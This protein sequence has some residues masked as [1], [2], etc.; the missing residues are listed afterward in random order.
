MKRRNFVKSLTA[1]GASLLFELGGRFAL[2]AEESACTRV[3][4]GEPKRQ[5]TA[6]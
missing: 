4:S 2:Q 1:A 5:S 6:T 3:L